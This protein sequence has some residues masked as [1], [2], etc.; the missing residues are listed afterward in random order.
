V[1][2]GD[3]CAAR[4]IHGPVATVLYDADVRY[5]AAAETVDVGGMYG[6]E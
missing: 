6:S 4:L 2:N 1:A 3:R 5:T